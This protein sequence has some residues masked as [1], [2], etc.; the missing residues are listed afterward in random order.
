MALDLHKTALAFVSYIN[1]DAS[2]DNVG[3]MAT[4]QQTPV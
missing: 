2:I 1:A 3:N 4:A